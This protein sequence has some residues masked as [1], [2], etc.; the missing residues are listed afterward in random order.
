[1]DV[2]KKKVE[3]F[4]RSELAPMIDL[5]HFPI[6]GR[7]PRITRDPLIHEMVDENERG[8]KASRRVKK[9]RADAD[10]LMR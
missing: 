8:C 6:V 4:F 9:S 5:V 1:L 7:E 10:P 3:G 2:F